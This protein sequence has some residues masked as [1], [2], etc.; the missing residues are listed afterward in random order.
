MEIY[1]W[2]CPYFRQRW[3]VG[4]PLDEGLRVPTFARDH[5]RRRED[6]GA[7]RSYDRH[8]S[9]P[10]RGSYFKLRLRQGRV[11]EELNSSFKLYSRTLNKY[12]VLKLWLKL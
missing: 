5:H 6:E 4:L 2:L 10:Y 8:E 1:H 3:T 12:F 11:E 7:D 9:Q